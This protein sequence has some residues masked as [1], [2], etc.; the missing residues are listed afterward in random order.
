MKAANRKTILL[1]ECGSIRRHTFE[2]FSSQSEREQRATTSQGVFEHL[3]CNNHTI[4]SSVINSG[5]W[6]HWE[7][8]DVGGRWIISAKA[9]T[10]GTSWWWHHLVQRLLWRWWSWIIVTVIVAAADAIG[11]IQKR[12]GSCGGS[13]FLIIVIFSHHIFTLAFHPIDGHAEDVGQRRL[14]PARWIED[15]APVTLTEWKIDASRVDALLD[16]VIGCIILFFRECRQ[17]SVGG[18]RRWDETS[19]TYATV[20]S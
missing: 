11:A 15:I 7:Q 4:R 6:C 16:V 19:P 13:D 1:K 3:R 20:S 17:F 14:H 18:E 2:P 12:G 10:L 5:R 8:G 9:H